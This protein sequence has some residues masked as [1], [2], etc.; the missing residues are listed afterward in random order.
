MKHGCTKCGL[1][2]YYEK[3]KKKTLERL[4]EVQGD[5]YDYSKVNYLNQNTPVEIICRKHGSFWQKLGT[6]LS[7]KTGCGKCAKENNKS[8]ATEFI[9]KAKKVHGDRYDYSKVDYVECGKKVLIGCQEHGFF[10]Q[11]AQSHLDGCKCKKCFIEE[12]KASR[13]NF[14]QNAKMIHGDRYDYSKVVYLGNKKPVEILCPLHGSFWQKPNSH[15]SSRAGCARCRESLGERQVAMV[16]EKYGIDFIRE[17]KIKPHLYR[18]DFYLPKF[19]LFIEFN[20]QQH[21]MAIDAFG[22]TKALLGTKVR[23]KIKADLVKSVNGELII[24]TYHS[25]SKNTIEQDL[26]K[27]LKRVRR[28]WLLINE[29]LHVFRKITDIYRYFNIPGSVLTRNV[30]FEVKKVVSDLK[31]LF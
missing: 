6:H 9:E 22:G 5:R 2:Q 14:I 8:N 3:R 1:E 28:Y 20:G 29:E 16:L 12:S 26:I 24:L 19:N 25:L 13:D 17:Y 11:R 27:Q 30:F 23:D 18:Y 15:V 21:Y 7:R 10:Y 31:E 4:K